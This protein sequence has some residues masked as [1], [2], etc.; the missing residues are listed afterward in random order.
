MDKWLTGEVIRAAAIPGV[1]TLPRVS[2]SWS[3]LVEEDAEALWQKCCADMKWTEKAHGTALW[4]LIKP[5]HDGCS[6]GIAVL[7]S[8]HDLEQYAHY[9]KSEAAYIPAGTFADQLDPIEMPSPVHTDYLIEPYLVTDR[10]WVEGL[11]LK[12][13]PVDG[14]LELTVGVVEG[15]SG[16]KALSPSITLASGGVLSLEEK[17][18]GGT[19]VNLTPPPSEL[20]SAEQ[21][22]LIRERVALAAEALEI[23]NYSRLDIFFNRLTSELILIEANTLPGMTASTV[24]Y[25][26]ALAETPPLRP[27][28]FIERIID[29]A[30]SRHALQRS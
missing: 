21:T 17:F 29:T 7:R 5:R 22:Q 16:L 28:E 23:R 15:D 30:Q 12:H 27:L 24:I 25:H 8:A 3:M 11:D 9:L 10:V 18:Q 13:E 19:G 6:A 14:W 2:L 4:L 20:I 1:G 26:Q